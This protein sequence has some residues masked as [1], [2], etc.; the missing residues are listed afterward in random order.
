MSFCGVIV[1]TAMNITFPTL[2]K[3]FGVAT[4]T[5]QWMTTLYLLVV[6]ALV[7]LSATFKRRFKMRSLFLVAIS[8]FIIGVVLDGIAPAFWVLLLGRGIQG[9]GTGIALPLMFNIILEQVPQSKVGMMMGIGTMITG[10]APAIGPTFG[11]L[12]VSAF[13]WRY[14]FVFLLPVLVFALVLGLLCIRQKTPVSAVHVDALSVA[15]IVVTFCS[16][17]FGISNLGSQAFMSL[18]VGGALLL[19]IVALA[20]FTRRSLTIKQPIINLRLF[21]TRAFTLSVL[22]FT[23]LQIAALGLSFLLPNYIQLVN[24]NSAL[25]AGLIVLPGAVLG[26]ILGPLSGRLYDHVG[27]AIPLRTG[28]VLTI[29]GT[30]V[31]FVFGRSLGNGLIIATYTFFMAGMGL[32]YGNIMTSGLSFLDVAQ[33]SDGNAIFNTV[34]QF[35]AALGTS[36]AA[37]M[38]AAGQKAASNQAV[39]TANGTTNALLVL[40]VLVV[41]ELFIALINTHKQAATH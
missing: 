2:M 9:L 4:N 41:V 39:G 1:E 12:V 34:Q 26:A 19:G 6:A 29:V 17:I 3:E 14:V 25:Q 8:F 33:Q 37:A 21:T 36:M 10:V 16:L 11:G 40:L 31:M 32:S 18:S 24:G 20:L 38:V 30:A 5:V 35:A 23:A 13:G 15:L 27:A 22:C 28:A 7:P